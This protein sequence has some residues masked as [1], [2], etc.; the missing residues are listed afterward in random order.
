MVASVA[1]IGFGLF[2][3]IFRNKHAQQYIRFQ[4]KLGF[5]VSSKWW[6]WVTFIAGPAYILIGIWLMIKDLFQL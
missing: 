6:K 5:K 2:I 3:I 4:R 1:F